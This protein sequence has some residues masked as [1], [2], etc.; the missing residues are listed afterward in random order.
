MYNELRVDFENASDELQKLV[1]LTRCP[2]IECRGTYGGYPFSFSEGDPNGP[3]VDTEHHEKP[4][5]FRIASL[6]KILINLAFCIIADKE[7]S[8]LHLDLQQKAFDIFYGNPGQGLARGRHLSSDPKMSKLLLH[9]G[10]FKDSNRVFLSP[11]GTFML[12]NTEEFIDVAV[13]ISNSP[14]AES[15]RATY[16][17]SSANHI[18]AA[19]I[20]EK[21]TGEKLDVILDKYIMEPFQ[22]THTTLNK[23]KLQSWV[24]DREV[25]LVPGYQVCANLAEVVR[26]PETETYQYM[27]D[28]LQTAFLGAWST[29]E[30]L[31]KLF[32]KIFDAFHGSKGGPISHKAAKG[33]FAIGGSAEEE[34]YTLAGVQ[35]HLTSDRT[36][37]ESPNRL[38]SGSSEPLYTLN[39][40]RKK[41]DKPMQ[42]L[43]K[44]ASMTG[45]AGTLYVEPEHRLCVVALAN[46][47]GPIDPTPHAA[48]ILLQKILFMKKPVDIPLAIENKLDALLRI[49]RQIE[50]EDSDAR[51][52]PSDGFEK[53]VGTY[54]NRPMQLTIE[55]KSDMRISFKRGNIQSAPL[56][57]RSLGNTI[58]IVPGRSHSILDRLKAWRN[59]DFQWKREGP[60]TYL[61]G[62]HGEE[63]YTK[64][65][66]RQV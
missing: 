60:K 12:S 49:P 4:V 35:V 32:G 44:G 21:V 6:V 62:N 39:L 16:E 58:R 42:L 43:Y 34:R 55:I 50:K 33:F 18:F 46:I 57:V 22:L 3:G 64:V 5:V 30:D 8:E 45:F 59:L 37:Q 65:E 20:L 56:P 29:T 2:L 25:T 47:A 66:E 41:K 63:Y 7:D 61:I 40:D 36:A 17:Y 48:H 38:L 26:V 15:S 14:S 28:S 13:G 19:Q 1:Q 52:W 27:D 31:V 23:D 10:G 54:K 11:D 24:K 53:F 9:M 51:S